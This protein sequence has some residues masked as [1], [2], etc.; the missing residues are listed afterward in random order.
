MAYNGAGQVSVQELDGLTGGAPTFHAMWSAITNTVVVGTTMG[1]AALWHTASS[2]KTLRL[3][4]VWVTVKSN[5][6]LANLTLGVK[7]TITNPA[8]GTAV[9]PSPAD[10]RDTVDTQTTVQ[11]NNADLWAPG[12]PPAY[13]ATSADAQAYWRNALYT[14]GS[15]GS[16]PAWGTPTMLY[17]YK[18][19]RAKALLLR[20]SVAEGF[21]VTVDTEGNTGLSLGGGFE[22]TEE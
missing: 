2:T 6:T 12:T 17:D 21:V 16:T 1:Y 9:T 22:W 18:P 14:A 19:G 15:S 13:A 7:R 10:P 8:G 5:S 11:T 20:P 4:R 3:V